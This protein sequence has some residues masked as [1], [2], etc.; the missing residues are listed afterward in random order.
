[1]ENTKY[2]FIHRFKDDKGIYFILSNSINKPNRRKAKFAPIGNVKTQYLKT[3]SRDKLAS[4]VLRIMD[5][6]INENY[7][8][9]RDIFYMPTTQNDIDEMYKQMKKGY[10]TFNL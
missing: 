5:K 3:I 9:K 8:S 1:M 7:D 6:Y 10:I 2:K 4:D